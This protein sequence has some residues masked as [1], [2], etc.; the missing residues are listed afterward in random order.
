MALCR[1]AHGH[2]QAVAIDATP[3]PDC[4]RCDQERDQDVTDLPELKRLMAKYARRLPDQIVATPTR[5]RRGM[6]YDRQTAAAIC[7]LMHLG[8]SLREACRALNLSYFTAWG[9]YGRARYGNRNRNKFYVAVEAARH[10]RRIRF[11]RRRT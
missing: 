9:W 5:G 11:K 6:R 7:A 2:E 10:A 3:P 4:E 8:L 1:C